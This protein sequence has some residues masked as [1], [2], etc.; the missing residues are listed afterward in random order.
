MNCPLRLAEFLTREQTKIE[1]EMER[2][3]KIYI[4]GQKNTAETIMT[5]RKK[6][7]DALD[8]MKSQ[9]DM[10]VNQPTAPSLVPST[11]TTTLSQT[12]AGRT[13]RSGTHACIICG[14]CL[15]RSDTLKNHIKNVHGSKPPP[16]TPKYRSN[17]RFECCF[18]HAEFSRKECVS[19]HM[20]RYHLEPQQHR[21]LCGKMFATMYNLRD[22][23]RNCPYHKQSSSNH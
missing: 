14:K 20:Q 22:H 7:R 15:S 4:Y 3:K 8:T 11:T 6:L 16:K 21:C 18:C 2:I 5:E 10:L 9:V 12:P 17:A 13:G 23:E 1:K 19:R